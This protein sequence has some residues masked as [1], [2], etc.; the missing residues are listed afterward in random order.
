MLNCAK[1]VARAVP[2]ASLWGLPVRPEVGF[3]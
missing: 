1:Q 3:G 2:K